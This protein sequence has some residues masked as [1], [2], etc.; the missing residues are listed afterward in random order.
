[1]TSKNICKR[2]F[3]FIRKSGILMPISSLPSQYGIGNFGEGA[4]KF[5]DF[6]D[7]AGQ[8]C[9]QVLPLNPTSYGDSPYQ[10]PASVAINPYFIDPYILFEKKLITSDELSLSKNGAAKV[11]YGWLF[12]GPSTDTVLVFYPGAKVEETIS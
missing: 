6:L 1:M 12:D 7:A 9:W 10:S 3:G 2:S 8:K 4:R 5:I 11:D